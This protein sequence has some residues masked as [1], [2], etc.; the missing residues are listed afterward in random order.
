MGQDPVWTDD[1]DLTGNLDPA[2][3]EA[4]TWFAT[5]HAD[6][7][8]AADRVAFRAWLRR[9]QRHRS[10]YADVEQMWAGASE[11][12][13]VKHGA[14]AA[15]GHLARAPSAWQGDCRRGGW[16]RVDGLSPAPI[17]DH[18]DRHRRAADGDARR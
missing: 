9:D 18:R 15:I 8:A 6:E 4:V 13:S 12:P 1:R 5:M 7:V 16:Q 11:L 14:G 17:C 2:S 3:Q 10:A